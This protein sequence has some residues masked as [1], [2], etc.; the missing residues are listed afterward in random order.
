MRLWSIHP[1]YLDSKGLVAL[2]REGLLAQKVLS[3]ET[4]GYKN[5]PQLVR[6]RQSNKQ[7]ETIGCYLNYILEEATRRGYN[8]DGS[9]I[10]IS[11]KIKTRLPVNSDQ[12]EYEF[13]H[14]LQ[15]LERR[16]P[17][18]HLSLKS[19]KNIKI[20]P[21]F[22]VQKGSIEGWEIVNEKHLLS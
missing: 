17:D 21:L 16:A 9:K 6:F 12:V 20:H 19:I 5:H 13:Q 1:E 15:K 10:I 11:E 14:L 18:L 4:N 3:G 2:W 8:F 7:L 22:K